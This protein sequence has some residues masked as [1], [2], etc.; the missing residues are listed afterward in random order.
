MSWRDKIKVKGQKTTAPRD[1][2]LVVEKPERDRPSRRKWKRSVERESTPIVEEKIEEKKIEPPKPVQKE[3]TV[4]KNNI[5]NYNFDPNKTYLVVGGKV[6]EIG[7]KSKYL[8]DM[9]IIKE[10]N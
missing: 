9:L 3:E 1:L 5:N 7:N 10:E 4:E 6:K 8:L 2:N